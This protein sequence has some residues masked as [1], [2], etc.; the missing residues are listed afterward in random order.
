[1]NKYANKRY[2]NLLS[3]SKLIK[4]NKFLWSKQYKIFERNKKYKNI[5]KIIDTVEK[6]ID[7]TNSNTNNKNIEE[8]INI[9]KNDLN[10]N[11]KISLN[12]KN[13]G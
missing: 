6:N 13:K 1:L 2:Y 9:T 4:I 5:S 10:K 8:N 3:Q 12:R 11:S 7:I